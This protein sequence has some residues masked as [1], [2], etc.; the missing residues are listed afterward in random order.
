VPDEDVLDAVRDRV[1]PA[2]GTT[3]VRLQEGRAEFVVELPA[4]AVEA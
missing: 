1:D 2:G 4:V 3:A